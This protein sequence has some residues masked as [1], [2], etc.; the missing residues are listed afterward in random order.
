M[1]ELII[2]GSAFFFGVGVAAGM[3]AWHGARVRRAVAAERR[4]IRTDREKLLGQLDRRFEDLRFYQEQ[5]S[6]L[7]AAQELAAEYDRGYL[8]GMRHGAEMSDV[9][10]MA[11]SLD[12]KQPGRILRMARYKG[13]QGRNGDEKGA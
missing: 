7:R 4:E 13:L 12:Q 9:E 6:S 11:Y 3:A 8:D 2:A 1:R 10:R 5:A